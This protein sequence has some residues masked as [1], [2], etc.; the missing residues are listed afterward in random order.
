M[1]SH[2]TNYLQLDSKSLAQRWPRRYDGRPRD[3]LKSQTAK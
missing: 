2:P 3:I 1:T